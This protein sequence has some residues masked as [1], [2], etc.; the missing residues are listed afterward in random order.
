ME[1]VPATALVFLRTFTTNPA[2]Q[3]AL[4][5]YNAI[6]FQGP[7]VDV[8]LGVSTFLTVGSLLL[9]A[10]L[11]W[12]LLRN[13][14][15]HNENLPQAILLSVL[16][17]V[18]ATVIANKTL[19]TQY[20]QWLAG[21]LAALLALGTSPWL[22]LPRRIL[23]TGLVIVAVLTQYTYPWGTLGIMA[24]PNGS[25]FESS[26]LVMRNTLLVLLAGF[27]AGLAWRASSRPNPSHPERSSLS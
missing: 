12:R 3:V 24:I 27:S 13:F 10:A 1:S 7:A 4:S 9:T 22:R 15:S 20:V 16:A 25:G 18:L 17:V 23:A 14:R 19:S 2:W 8:L 6:E 11:T 26:T 21:P 5:K